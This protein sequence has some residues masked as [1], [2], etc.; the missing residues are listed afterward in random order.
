LA[1]DPQH[2]GAL[3][4]LAAL[5]AQLGDRAAAKKLLTE[6]VAVAPL[7]A[8]AHVN[9]A[10]ALAQFDDDLAGART[11]YETALRLD[12]A[13]R[14]ANKGLAFILL[15][16]GNRDAALR[17]GRLA[18]QRG[19]EPEPYYGTGKP[20]TI[21]ALKSA[22][23]NIAIDRLVDPR[24]FQVWTLVVEFFDPKVPL[25]HH[26]VVLNC[27]G[28]VELDG[29]VE[30]VE[31]V[32]A[33]LG[34]TRARVINSPP[35]IRATGRVDNAGRLSGIDGI[36]TART[37]LWSRASL[38][39]P[40]APRELRQAGFTWPL[41]LRS[42]GFH[43]GHHF[44]RV[45]RAEALR[46]AVEQLPGNDL[47]VMQFL[48]TR[49]ADGKFR[50]FRVMFIGGEL[51]P[52]HLAVSARWKVHYYSADMADSP[53]NRAE[54]AAFLD[55]MQ[56]VVGARALE[57]LHRL[58]KVLGLDYGGVDFAVDAKG[59]I[60]VFEANATML[61]APV[62]EDPRWAY[63][64]PAVD[65]AAAATHRLLGFTPGTSPADSRRV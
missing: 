1:E 7:K 3:T 36:A 59:Q 48:D 51:Y 41:L 32:E 6:A 65:R 25:P 43:N 44:D 20:V 27:V 46:G 2:L 12:P 52:L 53:E 11:H 4:N 47:L 21:L 35:A 28:D 24:K 57:T 14:E 22:L 37:S 5:E 31:A 29:G 61:I 17:L 60:V 10:L 19:A 33:I 58:C 45:D 63:R 16:A 64:R 40:E 42:P 50:K 13:N 23:Q 39:A 30:A 8:S 54:D 26:D 18:F 55:D 34:R 49:G 9:L 62:G 38:L 15:R 56:S